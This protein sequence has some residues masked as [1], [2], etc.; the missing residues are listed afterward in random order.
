MIR[1]LASL[2]VPAAVSRTGTLLLAMPSISCGHTRA[3]GSTIGLGRAARRIGKEIP[4]PWPE[5]RPR[6]ARRLTLHIRLNHT[7]S[8][9]F[10]L[11]L[12]HRSISYTLHI[13][14]GSA[15]VRSFSKPGRGSHRPYLTTGGCAQRS[16]P[17]HLEPIGA[18]GLG[19]FAG[20][21][22]RFGDT[23]TSCVRLILRQQ[24][25]E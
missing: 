9:A 17:R 10:D 3:N 19:V 25:R 21:A 2:R 14:W 12:N 6:P 13:P 4:P 22:R 1:F 20:Q 18:G 16:G 24:L 7:R 15:G 11:Y 8:T 23:L 5:T